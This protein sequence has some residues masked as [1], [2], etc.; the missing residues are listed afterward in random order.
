LEERWRALKLLSEVSPA[1]RASLGD[2][3]N[4]YKPFYETA[5]NVLD[6]PRWNKIFQISEEDK[7]RYVSDFGMGCVMAR[8]LIAAD[9]GTRFVY[10]IDGPQPWD[11]H[12]FIFD[13]TKPR[14][15]YT[16]CLNLDRALSNLVKD[17]ASLPGRAAGK[18]LF[19]ETLVVVTSEF[20]RMPYMNNV[21]GRDH[22]AECYTSMFLGGGIKPSRIIGKTN[23]DCSKC[24]E[25][26]WKH[27][28]QPHMDNIVATIYSALG[29]DWNKRVENT[30]SGRAYEYI[31]S[32]PI[33]GG[34]FIS[35]DAIDELFE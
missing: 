21:F 12:S 24:I 29:I 32:A 34:E 11:H 9:A 20:G 26:G 19:D 23:E 14:S 28:E 18:S 25:T 13:R 16:T 4:D 33:G 35:D 31:Q 22:Y 6:D 10:V 5:F 1:E 7:K 17:L 2:K 30:P 15:H 8:N 27:K 3:A